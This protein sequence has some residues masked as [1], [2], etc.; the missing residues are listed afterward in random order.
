MDEARQASAQLQH[1]PPI[2]FLYGGND[3]VIP[4]QPTEATVRALG[5]DAEVH[6]YPRGYHM[7][8]RDLDGETIWRDIA[9]WIE[10]P[11]PH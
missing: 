4:R 10:Q 5:S 6:R 11:A 3:Q 9:D 8:L 2:L 7:L 1:S